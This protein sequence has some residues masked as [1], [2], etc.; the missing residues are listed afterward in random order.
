MLFVG[1][2]LGG[3]K[4]TAGLVTSAGTLLR[5]FTRP[6]PAAHGPTAV[7][8]TVVRLVREAMAASEEAVTGVGV[9]AAGVVD[10]V[11]GTVLSATDALPGWAGTPLRMLLTERL[12]VP[13][14]VDNDVY[15]HAMGEAWRGAGAG[16][17]RVLV[18]AAGTGVGG[19]LVL[20]GEP[21]R[22]ARHVAGSVGHVPAAEA[23]GLPCP[24]GGSGHLETVASGPG[25]HALYRRRGGDP[26]VGDAR[27]VCARAAA[28]TDAVAAA[29]VDVAASALG[30]ALGGV[31]NLYDPDV[32]IVGGGLAGAGQRWWDG[33]VG[34]V[35]AELMPPLVG[36]P[37]LPAGLGATAAVIGAA[38]AAMLAYEGKT[39]R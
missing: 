4:T 39:T 23:D 25:L 33:L 22:G 12:G 11:S 19:C 28:G 35:R 29:A 14:A 5:S 8:D 7:V 1:A 38:R 37:V 2:D 3:T 27:Q 15:A 30:R 13:V 21:Y 36:L 34:A 26:A 18:A 9:G 10:P 32:V 20:D 16:L 31:A 17:S 24:C 6:T